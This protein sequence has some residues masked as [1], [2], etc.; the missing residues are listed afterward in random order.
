MEVSEMELDMSK[1]SAVRA[2]SGF[3]KNGEVERLA[4]DTGFIV[5]SSSRLTGEAF[6]KMMVQNIVSRSE[7]SLSDQCVYLGEAHAI[8]MS[9][10]SL[11]ERYHTFTV[12]FMKRCY[13]H[14]LAR[15]F[16]GAM[17]SMACEFAGIYLTDS[18]SFQLPS[19]LS[20]FYQSN[21]GD[22]TGAS[23][24][25]HQTLELL[26]FQLKDLQLAD[27]KR[28]DVVY[29]SKKDFQ[30][31][32]NNLWIADLGHFSWEVFRRIDQSES[33]FLSRYKTG[34]LLYLKKGEDRYEPLDMEQY[35][36]AVGMNSPAQSPE[37]YFGEKKTKA[38]L[39]CEAV[40]EEV[41]QQRLHKY[42][43]SYRKQNKTRHWEM[44]AEKE[45]LCGYNLY[46][47]NAPQ[48][49]LKPEDVF[50][51]YGLRWQIELLFKIW[52]SLLFLDK[53]GQMNIFR[54]E[55]FLYGRLLFILLSTELMSFIKSTLKDVEADIEISEWKTMKL[56]KKSSVASST[57]L[58]EE[59]HTLKQS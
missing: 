53:V 19:H 49:K 51:I 59:N 45:L 57:L 8:E 38:R 9:R 1:L 41:R 28:N 39:I 47:T 55:C 54:F 11:D 44:S 37:I 27:G 43:Q 17:E 7:W 10:Q 3:F 22:T 31:G 21:G 40:P 46:L 4:K 5:R 12:A 48:Q 25:I 50:F 23:I 36:S 35:L 56:I 2:F 15:S 13:Q 30:W 34:T 58:L 14:V 29:W 42:W 24:K 16:R 33:Y 6:L 52:K 32:N 20:C 18:T 26:S